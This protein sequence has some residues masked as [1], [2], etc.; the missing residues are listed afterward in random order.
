MDNY[1]DVK[2]YLHNELNITK[3]YIEDLIKYEV[4]SQV[5]DLVNDKSYIG[6]LIENAVQR[7]L[8]RKDRDSWSWVYDTA[9]M[10]KNTVV[11]T[12]VDEVHNKVEIKLK[13]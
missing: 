12:I 11:K 7:E 5:A 10:I 8:R 1:K 6:T 13:E 4:Q 2:N 3:Q 9:S